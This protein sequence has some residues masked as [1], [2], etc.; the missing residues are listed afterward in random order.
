MDYYMY[1]LSC[2]L[3]TCIYEG[4]IY[5]YFVWKEKVYWQ[6][7][8][9]KR[10]LLCMAFWKFS[11]RLCIYNFRLICSILSLFF[12][13]FCTFFQFPN[14]Y[15]QLLGV[16]CC[17]HIHLFIHPLLGQYKLVLPSLSVCM[18]VG[19]SF[20]HLLL[21]RQHQSGSRFLRHTSEFE[22]LLSMTHSKYN[23]LGIGHAEVL[24][25]LKQF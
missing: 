5:L 12:S 13:Y 17:H 19:F 21:G 3:Y 1:Q 6:V 15:I 10:I 9:S 24:V 11:W 25:P 4:I 20:I 18:S 22:I 8:W 2:C 23:R 14:P 16:Y 7:N